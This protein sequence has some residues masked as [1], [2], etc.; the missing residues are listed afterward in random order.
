[1]SGQNRY[2]APFFMRIRLLFLPLLLASLRAVELPGTWSN[3]QSEFKTLSLMLR[4]DGQA[5]FATAVL[6]GFALWEKTDTGLLLTL[7]GDGKSL[8]IP[9]TYDPATELLTGKLQ[10]TEVVLKKISDQEPP[11]MLARAKE[12]AAEQQERWKKM[13][14]FED[15]TLAGRKA[16]RAFLEEW[17]GEPDPKKRPET[18][19][20]SAGKGEAQLTVRGLG[21]SCFLEIGLESRN[22]AK[23][24]GY[25]LESKLLPSDAVSDLPLSYELPAAKREALAKLAQTPG[26]KSETHAFSQVSV[27]KTESFFRSI[28]FIVKP[29]SQPDA[30]ELA[31]RILDILWEKPPKEFQAKLH[32][33]VEPTP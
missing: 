13:T 2:A 21:D 15:R 20:I 33:R 31:E 16:L 30:L 25:P 4:S 7:G 24:T 3:G 26:V 17:R 32:F 9:F 1:V 28:Q 10:N 22:L 8:T 5:V 11:D 6:P 29:D 23:L 14:R 12:R 27:F 18:V 19:F